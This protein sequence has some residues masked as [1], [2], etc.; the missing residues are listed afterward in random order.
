MALTSPNNRE[1]VP[2]SSDLGHSGCVGHIS[3]STEPRVDHALLC[4]LLG[5][6]TEFLSF[7]R[8]LLPSGGLFLACSQWSRPTDVRPLWLGLLMIY[9]EDPLQEPV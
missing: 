7:S 3:E 4:Y 6:P 1:H 2:G 9:G 8:W 5:C